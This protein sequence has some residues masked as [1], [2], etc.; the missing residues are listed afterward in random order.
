MTKETSALIAGGPVQGLDTKKD[1]SRRPPTLTPRPDEVP[2]ILAAHP[3]W[4][5]WRWSWADKQQKW[6][7]VPIHPSSSRNASSTDPATWGKFETV[8]ANLRL[9]DVDGIGFVFTANDPFCGVDLD[10]CRDPATGELSEMARSVVEELQGYSEVSV[11]GTGVHVIV[12][13]SL[14][15]HGGMKSKHVEVY[16]RGRY[17]AVS[18]HPLARPGAAK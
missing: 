15:C 11:T 16:D 14:G 18:G 13:A 2:I 3:Q 6:T 17:F 4:V 9:H 10:L 12:R 7:K 5:R 1:R 8:V